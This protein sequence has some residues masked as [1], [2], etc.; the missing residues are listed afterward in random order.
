VVEGQADEPEN[1][2]QDSKDAKVDE[3]LAQM[4]KVKQL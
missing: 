1:K 2:V 3:N 4:R